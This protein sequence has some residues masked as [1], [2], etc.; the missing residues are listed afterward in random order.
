[1]P[2]L[3]GAVAT[4]HI[5]SL[6]YGICCMNG[7]EVMKLIAGEGEG[8]YRKIEWMFSTRRERATGFIPPSG[9]MMSA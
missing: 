4:A 6:L 1:M 2:P 5:V 3:P 8:N 7:I 9:M